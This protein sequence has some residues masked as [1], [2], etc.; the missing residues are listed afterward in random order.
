VKLICAAFFFILIA[1]SPALPQ[2]R[3]NGGTASDTPDRKDVKG[4]GGHLMVVKDPQGFIAE[5]LK[6]ETPHIKVAR[7][8]KRG[9]IHGALVLFAGCKPDA[10]GICNA[11]VDYA[12]YNP[13]GSLREEKKALPLWK[14]EAPP[15]PII[16]LGRALLTFRLDKDAP[17]GEYKVK[18][19]VHDLNA[20]ISF[21][22]ETKF[23]V[24]K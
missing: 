14:D 21:E 23:S 17:A 19:K 24:E 11:E 20:D 13:D 9:E 8:V 6:P 1:T 7:T 3:E 5:W 15:Q 18:A 10:K 16:Q 12:I 22:L 4:F 2:W